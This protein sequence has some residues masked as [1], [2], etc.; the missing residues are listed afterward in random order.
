MELWRFFSACCRRENSC[1]RTWESWKISQGFVYLWDNSWKL[2]ERWRN[3]CGLIALVVITSKEAA[4]CSRIDQCPWWMQYVISF[5]YSSRSGFFVDT[6]A[7][8]AITR[9]A[10]GV[11]QSNSAVC[12]SYE[13]KSA[14]ILVEQSTPLDLKPS[15]PLP[16]DACPSLLP[17][18]ESENR[19]LP[20]VFCCAACLINKLSGIS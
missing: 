16:Q 15:D 13:E 14:G 4:A 6:R 2:N 3:I 12:T 9:S 19:Y 11:I 8:R 10:S 1:G 5:L 18:I 17:L 20:R 7:C